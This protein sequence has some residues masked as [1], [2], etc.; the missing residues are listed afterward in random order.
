MPWALH[1]VVSA[2]AGQAGL[3]LDGMPS[4]DAEVLQEHGPS[5]GLA[6]VFHEPVNCAAVERLRALI[7]RFEKALLLFGLLTDYKCS[8][9]MCKFRPKA[10]VHDGDVS[11]EHAAALASHMKADAA[12]P[13]AEQREPPAAPASSA[14]LAT[15]WS[16]ANGMRKR[17][18][19]GD[20]HAHPGPDND[21]A[22]AQGGAAQ[23][24][25]SADDDRSTRASSTLS[26]NR[27]ELFRLRNMLPEDESAT[28]HAGQIC[29]SHRNV[30]GWLARGKWVLILNALM[31]ANLA[32]LIIGFTTQGL[33]EL[34]LSWQSALIISLWVP[35]CCLS[36][37]IFAFRFGPGDME[38][39]MRSTL[40][41]AHNA[42]RIRKRLV[43]FIWIGGVLICLN[44]LTVPILLLVNYNADPMSDAL[45]LVRM[46]TCPLM[47][48]CT[49][50]MGMLWG[51]TILLLPLLFLFSA[52]WLLPLIVFTLLCEVL[53]SEFEG[54]AR[55]FAAHARWRIMGL[56]VKG[57]HNPLCPRTQAAK[58]ITVHDI[59]LRHSDLS[60]IV[61]N[62]ADQVHPY[63][64]V[65][66]GFTLP[67]GVFLLY[68][69]LA[70]SIDL[71]P[72]S[73]AVTSFW[74][75]AGLAIL[76]CVSYT[77]GRL[78]ESTKSIVH[79]LL[80][81]RLQALM[82]PLGASQDGAARSLQELILFAVTIQEKP[83]GIRLGYVQVTFEVMGAIASILITYFLVVV[84][85]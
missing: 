35:Y 71:S 33:D 61:N 3:A 74:L 70:F 11:A 67:L 59:K 47:P 8:K 26:Q 84:T 24:A 16:S 27:L 30:W 39:V 68:Q 51:Y 83:S 40:V 82:A 18:G 53:T 69:V 6:A 22:G 34:G 65:L 85:I 42:D 54:L 63:V 9:K 45:E 62:F 55:K 81:P 20:P 46:I 48:R 44:V 14:G 25:A 37:L 28:P 31:W 52:V 12:S 60:V 10:Q 64:C 36:M 5:C 80:D 73:L 21:S 7:T 49:E 57:A 38:A 32:R 15:K 4:A 43:K 72:G 41:T 1:S 75:L 23:P 76:F 78:Y 2:A 13:G 77:S 66:Y 50:T 19:S 17:A 79:E 58:K 56:A 29:M